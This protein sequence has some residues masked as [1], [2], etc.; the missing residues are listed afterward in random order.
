MSFKSYPQQ[1]NELVASN[2]FVIGATGQTNLEEMHN[3][4][5]AAC[6]DPLELHDANFNIELIEVAEQYNL[7]LLES[8]PGTS[9]KGSRPNLVASV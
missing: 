9:R 7:M 8:A 3:P 5:C 6:N 1:F 2:P 4:A